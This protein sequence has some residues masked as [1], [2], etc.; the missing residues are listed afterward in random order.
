[1]RGKGGEEVAEPPCSKNRHPTAGLCNHFFLAG[2]M[3]PTR[4]HEKSTSTEL[5]FT[6]V[7]WGGGG[8]PCRPSRVHGVAHGVNS[9]VA[10][11]TGSKLKLLGRA[12]ADNQNLRK[13]DE[14]QPTNQAVVP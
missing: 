10:D 13:Q 4:L 8:V 3:P 11:S 9:F 6:G 1:M 7:G 2:G 14:V 5:R 12:E